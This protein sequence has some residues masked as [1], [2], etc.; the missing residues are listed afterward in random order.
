M[1]TRNSY[2]KFMRYTINMPPVKK[3]DSIMKG[4]YLYHVYKYKCICGKTILLETDE[5]PK[6]LIKC[7]DCQNKGEKNV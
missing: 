1:N 6:K 3:L 7:F 4:K 2:K 5:K